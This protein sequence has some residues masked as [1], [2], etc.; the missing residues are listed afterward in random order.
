MKKV[1]SLL[2]SIM[3][4][5]S[6]IFSANAVTESEFNYKLNNL[7]SK[8][9]NYSTWYDSFD[10]GT[11]CYGFAR[12]IAYEVFGT[13]A[14]SWSVDYSISGVK[15]GDVLQY[16]PT[17]GSGHTVFVTGVSGDTITFVDCNGNGNYSGGTKVRT[18]GI[19]W[20]NT[21]NKSG[22]MY[23]KITFSYRL[24]S[25]QFK[26]DVLPTN[27]TI[28]QSQYWYD[29]L[30][31]IKLTGYADNATEYIAVIDDSKGNR[32]VDEIA[33]S[34]EFTI[35]AETLINKSGYGDYW[36]C[37]IMRNSVGGVQSEW[38]KIPI[39][40][41]AG[42]S[43]VF[44]SKPVYDID[45]TVSISVETICADGQ[46]IGI[47][48]DGVGRVVTEACDSTF[49]IPAS[50][51][52]IGT[53][54]A[55]FSV[56]NGSG[57]IDTKRVNYTIAERKNLGDEF[58]AKIENPSS[59]KFLTAVGNNVEGVDENCDKHQ[60]WL[61]YKLSDNSY[62]I[63]NYY[64]W[65]AMDVDN[66]ASGGAGTNVQ[67]YND[68]DVTA[69]R[70]YIYEVYGAYYLK[71]VCTDMVLDLSQ[72]TY[73]LEVWGMGADW[74]AQKFNILKI[75]QSDIGV[76]K[77][78]S[79]LVIDSDTGAQYNEYTCSICKDSYK[80][81][82]EPEFISGDVNSDDIVN[83]KDIV[84][85]QQYLN[86]WDVDINTDASDVNNDDMINMK[87]IVLLQQYMN[88]WD[89]ELV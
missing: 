53:Y 30:D 39:V 59:G 40:D 25:P 4:I 32:L 17:T 15:P 34:N 63:K 50:N 22:K 12:L 57:G 51:L 10:G 68:W 29:K 13:Y 52:G 73:N 11:Q 38:I 41:S 47:D 43:N 77:Y 2:L 67:V 72:T 23:G 27:P 81:I 26:S 71:P 45:D 54:S 31:T 24:V 42:Y 33:P 69:Q 58:C 66:Y 44:C 70:F 16:G 35:S 80:E 76:H 37:M 48:K 19:K 55:Y 64:D 62:K 18:C 85:L 1:I 3:I 87:D 46:V 79:K 86:N 56:Y 83:M 75:D 74:P 78:E 89:V 65:R 88:G 20:D 21:I 9:P 84:L 49:T 8:Y 28:S 61:F 82:I 7:R 36:A 5:M 6:T 60:V 14:S